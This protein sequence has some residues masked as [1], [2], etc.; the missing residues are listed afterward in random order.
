VKIYRFISLSILLNC[1]RLSSPERPYW[2]EL[3]TIL[4]QSKAAKWE[5]QFRFIKNS[6]SI[7]LLPLDRAMAILLAEISKDI[8]GY[9]VGD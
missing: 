5:Y 9:F 2:E 1:L 8:E 3:E 4:K 6:F 7:L